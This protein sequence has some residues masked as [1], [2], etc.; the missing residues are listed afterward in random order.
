MGTV[1]W[2]WSNQLAVGLI[3][4]GSPKNKTVR[5]PIKILL[6]FSSDASGKES[7]CQCRSHGRGRFSPW[8]GK[9]PWRRAWQ[10]TP[11]FLPGEFHGQRGLVGYSPGVTQSQTR[12]KQLNTLDLFH[13]NFMDLFHGNPWSK[14]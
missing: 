9:I 11:V 4:H 12:L 3:D 6:T 10:P 7:T 13:G 1:I 2:K 8:V 5:K 14:E